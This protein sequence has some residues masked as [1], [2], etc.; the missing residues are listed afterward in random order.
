M[1]LIHSWLLIFN[2]LCTRCYFVRVARSSTIFFFL[3]NFLLFYTLKLPVLA[4]AP[5]KFHIYKLPLLSS[6]LLV[7]FIIKHSIILYNTFSSTDTDSLLFLKIYII[8]YTFFVCGLISSHSSYSCY[9]IF[10]IYFL[11]K[12]PVLAA[13]PDI[14]PKYFYNRQASKKLLIS[15]NTTIILYSFLLSTTGIIQF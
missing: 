12:L 9:T 1:L 7:H 10:Y 5:D 14:L 15:I 2:F 13:A 8:Q 3:L 6:L 11:I 4:A